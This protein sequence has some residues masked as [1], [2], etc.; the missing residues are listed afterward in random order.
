MATDDGNMYVVRSF[1]I[2]SDQ[3]SLS[4]RFDLNFDLFTEK[5]LPSAETL[6]VH[7]LVVP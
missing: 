5:L 3:R 7:S 4:D 1:E 6:L 2:I